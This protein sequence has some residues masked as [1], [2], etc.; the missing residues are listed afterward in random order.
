MHAEVVKEHRVGRALLENGH[1][2]GDHVA[3][4]AMAAA[5]LVPPR[6]TPETN[7]TRRGTWGQRSEGDA[8]EDG[9]GGE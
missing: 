5:A 4:S 1:G 2:P 3:L 9:F 7:K 8:D 6:F